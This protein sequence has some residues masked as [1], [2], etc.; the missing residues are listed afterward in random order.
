MQIGQVLGCTVEEILNP[1]EDLDRII[2][3]QNFGH[4]LPPSQATADSRGKRPSGDA[5][6]E[7]HRSD[8]Y[9]V[10]ILDPNTIA[11]ATPPEQWSSDE[12]ALPWTMLDS[13]QAQR[14]AIVKVADDAMSPTLNRGDWIL[15]D[16]AISQPRRDGVYVLQAPARLMIRRLLLDPRADTVTILADNPNYH[17]TNQT[18]ITDIHVFGLA[19]WRG[20]AL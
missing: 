4:L 2:A 16:R 11:D 19:L 3:E 9:L 13:L 6:G 5:G 20:H 1:P 14:P 18:S 10:P 15:I 7:V 17:L 12:L 8:P